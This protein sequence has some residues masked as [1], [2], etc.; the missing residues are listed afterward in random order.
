MKK[1]N[2]DKQMTDVWR[3]PAFGRWEKSCLETANQQ[4]QFDIDDERN[5]ML[6]ENQDALYGLLSFDTKHI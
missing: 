5:T 3:L 1:L 4:K 6:C 2:D